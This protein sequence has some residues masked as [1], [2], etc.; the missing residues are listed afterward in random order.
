MGA[1]LETDPLV[2]NWGDWGT[3][4]GAALRRGFQAYRLPQSQH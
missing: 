3:D 2:E 1:T 4:W